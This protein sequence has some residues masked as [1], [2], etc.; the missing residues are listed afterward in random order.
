[1][2]PPVLRLKI[3]IEDQQRV[4]YPANANLAEVVRDTRDTH[5]TA[6]MKHNAAAAAQAAQSP[7]PH[8]NDYRN[9]L[10]MDFCD[11]CRWDDSAR[12]WV[13]R[14]RRSDQIGR[15]YFVNPREGERY[16]LRLLLCHVPG[17]TTYN[18][19]KTLDGELHPTFK[20]KHD[21]QV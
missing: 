11:P 1:M 4:T 20:V 18:D 12:K 17:A 7:G 16:Y 5:L 15:M 19:L 8:E 9:V 10:Y 21:F 6:W 2:T 3:H 13:K 14:I